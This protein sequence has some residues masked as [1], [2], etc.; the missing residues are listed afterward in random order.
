MCY[1]HT[2][3]VVTKNKRAVFDFGFH[4]AAFYYYN[5]HCNVVA[6][7][8]KLCVYSLSPRLLH[9]VNIECYDDTVFASLPLKIN[10]FSWIKYGTMNAKFKGKKKKN[11][12][13]KNFSANK[14]GDAKKNEKGST[15]PWQKNEYGQAEADL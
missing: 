5:F 1:A 2:D 11:E 6:H 7:C 8:A 9:T 13:N 14:K 3:S 10:D 12:T 4:T 15:K